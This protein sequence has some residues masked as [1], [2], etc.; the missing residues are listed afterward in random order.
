MSQTAHALDEA[1][2]LDALR[3]P[4]LPQ[5]AEGPRSER[6]RTSA[7]EPAKNAD[8]GR[9]GMSVALAADGMCFA[10]LLVLVVSIRLTHPELF[11]Y[12]RYFLQTRLGVAE[13]SILLAS[14]L[15][16]AL[17]ARLARAPSR[18][19]VT[20]CLALGI[21]LG[22][23]FLGVEAY[24][25]SGLAERGLLPGSRFTSS[26]PVWQTEEFRHEHPDAAS[27]A[28]AFRIASA[29]DEPAVP[30]RP[31]RSRRAAPAAERPDVNVRAAPLLA[32]GALGD[33]AVYPDVPSQPRNA[34]LFFG[35]LFT[36]MGAHALHVLAGALFWVWLL[37]G[38]ALRREPLFR[39][40]SGIDGASLYFTFV[41]LMRVVLFPL[42]YLT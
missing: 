28:D 41:T 23:G 37:A 9:M 13:N 39:T 11:A 35:L 38:G 6:R 27:Y 33:R 16:G 29:T 30:A 7:F 2:T 22:V 4:R 20:A 36:A 3:P 14:M 5:F 32:A 40:P 15:F 17:A 10:S 1:A 26:E 18:R 24:E 34:H 8:A 42:F 21:A 12:G 25:A 19:S 31:A